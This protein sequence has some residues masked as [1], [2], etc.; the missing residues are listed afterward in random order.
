MLSFAGPVTF[1]NARELRE[2]TALVPGQL[3]VGHDAPFLTHPHRGRTSE[4]LS[5]V[6]GAGL[7][8]LRNVS[9][10]RLASCARRQR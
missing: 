7:A 5:A 10:E 3:L 2:A 1:K 4:L 6:D 8:A 9:D